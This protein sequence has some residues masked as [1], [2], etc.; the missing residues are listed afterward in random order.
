[1]KALIVSIDCVAAAI[2]LRY[3]FTNLSRMT[4]R[5]SHL[6]RLINLIMAVSAAAILLAPFTKP[7][8]RDL[9]LDVTTTALLVAVAIQATLG[10]RD[11]D[12]FRDK[13]GQ[14]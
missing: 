13:Q 10:R 11:A 5:C 14:A 4:W 6:H 12:R 2:L 3:A 7:W 9:W 8:E 1:M